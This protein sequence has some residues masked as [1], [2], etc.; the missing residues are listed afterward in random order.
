MTQLVLI[1]TSAFKRNL[2]KI[3]LTKKSQRKYKIKQ[4]LN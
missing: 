4:N 1:I 3:E 2:V